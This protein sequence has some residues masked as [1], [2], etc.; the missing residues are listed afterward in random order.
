MTLQC[1]HMVPHHRRPPEELLLSYGRCLDDPFPDGEEQEGQ[2]ETS[3]SL[4]IQSKIRQWT[5]VTKKT[6]SVIS[7]AKMTMKKSK[8]ELTQERLANLKR[9]R[10][11]KKAH[12]GGAVVASQAS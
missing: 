12:E 3:A 6:P 1:V 7:P 9:G 10:D 8:T 2:S 11:S 4:S 5:P